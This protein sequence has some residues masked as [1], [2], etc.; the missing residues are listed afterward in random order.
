MKPV[1]I[2]TFG[3]SGNAERYNTKKFQNDLPIIQSNNDV[4]TVLI[5]L[6]YLSFNWRKNECYV[7]NYEVAGKLTKVVGY[8]RL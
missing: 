8:G 7:P 4:L 3:T 1:I 6:G 2:E 5:H